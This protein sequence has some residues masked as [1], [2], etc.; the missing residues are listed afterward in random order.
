MAECILGL[1]GMWLFA[2]MI[3]DAPGP[4]K[5]IERLYKLTERR[6]D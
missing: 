6:D 2:C 3:L 5:T 1:A 4:L